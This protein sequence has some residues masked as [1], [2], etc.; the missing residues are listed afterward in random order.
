MK[1]ERRSAND[2]VTIAPQGQLKFRPTELRREKTDF[3]RSEQL[4]YHLPDWKM[5]MTRFD[6]RGSDEVATRRRPAGGK[7]ILGNRVP[8]RQPQRLTMMDEESFREEECGKDSRGKE[9]LIMTKGTAA[10]AL[11]I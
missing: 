9:L 6:D 3:F 4:C 2:R 1:S 10:S 7:R 8:N 5:M 11:G